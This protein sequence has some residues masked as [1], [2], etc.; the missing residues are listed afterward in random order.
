MARQLELKLQTIEDNSKV[1]IDL[2]DQLDKFATKI[3]KSSRINQ[4][5]GVEYAEIFRVIDDSK[6][7]L[8]LAKEK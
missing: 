8:K 2:N 6:L 5:K 7:I 4:V 3:M 1:A